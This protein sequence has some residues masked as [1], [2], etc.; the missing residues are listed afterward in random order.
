MACSA[1]M[2]EYPKN[3]VADTIDLGEEGLGDDCNAHDT[4]GVSIA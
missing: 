3:R 1:K 4:H 2:L